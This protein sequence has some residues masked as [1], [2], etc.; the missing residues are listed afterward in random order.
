MQFPMSPAMPR[1]RKSIGLDDRVWATIKHFA[2]KAK[3]QPLRWLER[4]LFDMGKAEG[5]I[6]PD[7]EYPPDGRGGAKPGAGRP[8]GDRAD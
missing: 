2:N 6:D 4:H 3:L 8:K 7:A 5:V 1:S